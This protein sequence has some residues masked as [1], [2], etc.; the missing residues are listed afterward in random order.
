MPLASRVRAY[1]E[2]DPLSGMQPRLGD[3]SPDRVGSAQMTRPDG[4]EP[5]LKMTLAAMNVLPVTTAFL[6]FLN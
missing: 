2:S 4:P 3:G 1:S 6:M 5:V